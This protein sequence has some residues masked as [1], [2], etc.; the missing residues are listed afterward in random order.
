MVWSSY[1]TGPQTFRGVGAH[2]IAASIFEYFGTLLG[3]QPVAGAKP[4]LLD[5]FHSAESCGQL[6]TQQPRVCGLVREAAYS[7]KLLVDGVCG[8]TA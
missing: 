7:G 2:A 6:R 3:A 4:E 1:H 5:P 8:Q